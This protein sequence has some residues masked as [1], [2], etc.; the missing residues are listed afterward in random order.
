MYDIHCQGLVHIKPV[1]DHRYRPYCLTFQLSGASLLL[2]Q[3]DCITTS[4]FCSSL[5][6]CHVSV[7]SY[8]SIRKGAAN[9]RKSLCVT[10]AQYQKSS[11]QVGTCFM[12]C[13]PSAFDLGCHAGTANPAEALCSQLAAGDRACLG[14]PNMLSVLQTS[15][16]KDPKQWHPSLSV[17]WS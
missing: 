3:H 8:S 17:L 1:D 16:R 15:E 7:S 6:L 9:A 2:Q 10:G 13:W 14:M 5:H 11:S 4:R 12:A